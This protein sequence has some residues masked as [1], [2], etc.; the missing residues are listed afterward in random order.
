MAFIQS[1]TGSTITPLRMSI[2]GQR[3]H[4]R[5]QL[6]SKTLQAARRATTPIKRRMIP[7]NKFLLFMIA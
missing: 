3:R 5:V 4:K 1:F 2:M 6:N 7:V